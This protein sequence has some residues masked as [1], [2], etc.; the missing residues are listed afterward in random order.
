MYKPLPTPQAEE[1]RPES[2]V[3]R[4][5]YYYDSWYVESAAILLSVLSLGGTCVVAAIYNGRIL[6]EWDAPFS[7]NAVIA[8]LGTLLKGSAMLAVTAALCQLRWN[9]LSQKGRRFEHFQIF[10][11]ASRG[12]L[13][14]VWLLSQLRLRLFGLPSIGAMVVIVALASDSFIQAAVTFPL[15]SRI[16]DPNGSW[17]AVARNYSDHGDNWLINRTGH[18]AWDASS[19][20]KSALYTGVLAPPEN[21]PQVLIACVTGNCTVGPYAT[22]EIGS[23]CI[24]NTANLSIVKSDNNY[25]ATWVLDSEDV[26]T[27]TELSLAAGPSLANFITMYTRGWL[28]LRDTDDLM[29]ITDTHLIIFNGKSTNDTD[30]GSETPSRFQ[31]YTCNFHLAV[32]IYNSTVVQGS[33]TEWPLKIRHTKQWTVCND[34]SPGACPH[35]VGA[36]SNLQQ[37]PDEDVVSI[38]ALSYLSLSA[39]LAGIDPYD[40]LGMLNGNGTGTMSGED[41]VDFSGNQFPIVQ[42][43]NDIIKAIHDYGAFNVE[44]AWENMA[45]SMTISMRMSNINIYDKDAQLV[46]GAATSLQP[47]IYI[48]WAWLILPAAVVIV[49]AL[50]VAIVAWQTRAL[51]VPLWKGNALAVALHGFH[52]TGGEHQR[53]GKISEMDEWAKRK[54]VVL[55]IDEGKGWALRSV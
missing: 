19:A 36:I 14:S 37:G 4:R 48:Q 29:R 9:W 15:R 20:M 53:L 47:Y 3:L 45:R 13:G 34:Y 12:P 1:V 32:Q 22:L 27:G 33:L 50:L 55:G 31:A 21:N 51:G 30:Y 44:R 38:S 42:W 52:E 8:V 6:W 46:W 5:S 2:R 26:E 35:G 16:D 24:N 7:L 10:D 49:A 41:I 43:T 17:I 23:Q 18:W 39:Y 54:R 28:T 40:G 25:T 11:A